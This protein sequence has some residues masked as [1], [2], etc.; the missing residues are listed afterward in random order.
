M[1]LTDIAMIVGILAAITT[2]LSVMSGVSMWY[3][4]IRLKPIQK[5][6]LDI[7]TQYTRITETLSLITEGLLDND[8]IPN[9][10]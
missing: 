4:G 9:R 6:I 8:Q 5:D 10:K 3:I 1:T 7:K 2:I